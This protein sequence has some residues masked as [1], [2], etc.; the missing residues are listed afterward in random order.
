MATLKLVY[1]V[2]LIFVVCSCADKSLV[3][4][5]IEG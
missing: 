5:F 1:F 3:V 4:H 2:E